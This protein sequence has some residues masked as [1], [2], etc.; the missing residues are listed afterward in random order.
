MCSDMAPKCLKKSPTINGDAQAQRRA[1]LP[2]STH[3]TWPHLSSDTDSNSDSSGI[4]ERMHKEARRTIYLL[5]R[6]LQRHYDKAI[7]ALQES[8][9][10]GPGVITVSS[11]LHHCQIRDTCEE[12][13]AD[14][15][16]AARDDCCD[17]LFDVYEDQHGDFSVRLHM[18]G[19]CTYGTAQ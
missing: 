18:P 7:P 5:V 12:A 11:L 2:E 14:A 3:A 10:F 1:H 9:Q 15:C 6:A 4:P 17:A 16:R 13:M 19:Y 8:S